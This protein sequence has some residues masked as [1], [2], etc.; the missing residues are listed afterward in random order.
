[1]A[2]GDQLVRESI[3]MQRKQFLYQA[4]LDV[5]T[6]DNGT[7]IDGSDFSRSS[8]E[9]LN[10]AGVGTLTSFTAKIMGSNA[11]LKPA[12]SADGFTIG[13][14]VTAAG[15]VAVNTPARWYKVKVTAISVTGGAKLSALMH[16]QSY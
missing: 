3:G 4:L 15:G 2:Q 9:F 8:I 14:D 1:M 10:S 7:W 6:T 11:K 5:V 12:D 13:A 16:G